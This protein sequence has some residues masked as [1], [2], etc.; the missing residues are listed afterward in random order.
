[1]DV[2]E[3]GNKI[4]T[5]RKEKGWTQKEIAERLHI[6][7]AAVS[8]WERG[9]NYPDLSLMEPLAELLGITVAELLGVV[10]EPENSI[11]KDITEISQKEKERLAFSIG[12]RMVLSVGM[13][14]VFLVI[15]TFFLVMGRNKEGSQ[16]LFHITKSGILEMIPLM[17]G[18]ISWILAFAGILFGRGRLE[19]KWKR[20]SFVSVICCS[21]ALYFPSAILDYNIRVGDSSAV[22]DIVW[23]LHYAA[24]VLLIGTLLFNGLSWWI[25]SKRK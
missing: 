25:N 16:M 11:I 9:L 10:N 19:N 22:L 2:K 4:A 3:V 17:L 18:L 15:I 5:I 24:A 8:K 6:S 1:M 23:G 20:Y 21:I 14:V 13:T 7:T 12:K